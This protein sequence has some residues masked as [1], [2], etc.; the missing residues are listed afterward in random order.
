[1][2]FKTQVLSVVALFLAI[3]HAASAAST[4]GASAAPPKE[5]AEEPLYYF[6]MAGLGASDRF[7]VTP[8]MRETWHYDPLGIVLKQPVNYAWK[9]AV[10]KLPLANVPHCEHGTKESAEKARQSE[11]EQVTRFK[12]KIVNMNWHYGQTGPATVVTGATPAPGA[13]TGIE[14]KNVKDATPPQAT[15]PAADDT[16]QLRH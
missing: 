2:G 3:P 1:M 10:S 13:K 4:A 16:S 7:Y 5:R 6:C 8:V 11:I 15:V 9:Q 14:T 12:H